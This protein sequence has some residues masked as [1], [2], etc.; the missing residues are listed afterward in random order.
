MGIGGFLGD[1]G[2]GIA[3]GL[4]GAVQGANALDR[5]INPFHTEQTLTPEG[6]KTAQEMGSSS[7]GL[8]A[9]GLEDTMSGMRWLYSN[10]VSQPLATAALVGKL[11]R[12]NNND[13]FGFDKDF[14]S[15]KSWT[16]SWHAANHISPGQAL[17]LNPDEAKQAI[18]SPLLYYKP[19]EAYLPPGFKN[20]P[21]DQQQELLHE[22]GMPAV[23]NAFIEKKRGD[24]SWFKYGTG[25]LDFASVT[26]ADPTAN[27]LGVVGKVRQLAIVKQMP[28]G[29][30]SGA[31]ID[32]LINQS[33]M[34]TLMKGIWLNKDNPQLINNT[35]LA[36]HSG[37][38]PRFGAIVSKLQDQDELNLFVRT[39]M[40]DMRAMD[41]LTMRNAAAG[42]RLR[43]DTSRLSAL[44][45]MKTR[46]S[47]QPN[48]QA[49]IDSEMNRISTSISADTALVDRYTSIVGDADA[50]IPGAAN[51]IDQ[52][53]VSR[54]SM[55]RAMDRTAAQNEYLAGPARGGNRPVTLRPSLGPVQFGNKGFGLN[56][57]GS[58]GVPPTPI[59]TG[60]I[61]SN[62]WGTGDYFSGPV[63]LVRSLKNFHPNG[64]MRVDV[65]DKDS[66]NELRGHLARIPGIKEDTRA[67]ILNSYL[68]T[69]TEAQRLDILDDVG[70]LGAAK[71]AQRHGLTPEDGEAFYREHTKRF[72]G[73]L[74]DMQRYSAALRSPDDVAAGMPLHV[75]EFT[76]DG[77]KVKLSPFT[78]TRLANG[79][80]FQDL[81]LFDKVLSRHA[82]KFQTLRLAMGNT[83]DAME[84]FADYSSFLWK[85]AALAR[86]GYIPRVLGDD[87][88]SQWARVG[89]AAMALRV[90]KGVKNAFHN[91]ALSQTRPA[92]EAREANARAGVGYAADEM[93]NLAPQIRK[94]EGRFATEDAARTRDV[95]LSQQRLAR[96]E[97]RLAN[98]GPDATE[99][100]RN[101]LQTFV[102]GKRNEVTRANTRA[103]SPTWP[104]KAQQLKDMKAQHDFL[105]RYHDLSARA[106]DDYAAQQLKARQ[107][108]Q[109]VEIDGQM[110]PAAFGGREGEYYHALTSA[111]DSVGNLFARN[112]QLVQ[113]N[114]ERSFDHGAKPIS[115][116]QDEVAHANAWTHAINNVIMQ[117]PLQ[118]MMV[119]GRINS[120]AEA[121][122]WMKTTPGG[123]AYR[124]RLPKYLNDEDIA[125]SQRYEIDSYMHLPEI[126]MK[127][128]E[129]GGVTPDFLKKATP[130]I[131][132][133]PDV[134]LGQVGQAQMRH[135]NALDRVI[136][137]WYR[138]AAT[139]PANKMS[140]H[141]LFNQFYEGH[142]KKITNQRK[143]QQG[144]NPTFT[145]KDVE[146]I[147]HASRQLALRDMR[148]LVFDIAHRS[149][150]A[151]ASRYM[152]PFFSATG[153]A[154]QRW[155]RVIADKPQIAGYAG[156]WYNAPAYN[157]AMQD[158]DGNTV[159]A[160]GN[161]YIPI[162]PLKADGTPDYTK[163]P[164]VVKRQVPKS[165]R[166]I[167]T[168][169]PK[170]FAE[171]PL[172]AAFNVTQAGGKLSLS[173]NSLDMVTQGDPWFNPGLGPIV[174]IPVNEL[175]KDKPRAAEM[176]RALG[177]LPFG[178]QG[179]GA[180]GDNPVGRAVNMAVPAQFRNF[181]TAYDTS[182]TR[183]QQI[184][185]Q[186]MQR[187]IYE[188]ENN[189]KKML[190][191]Q[192]IADQTRNYWLF[193]ASSSFLQPVATTRKDPYQF[194]RDQYNALRNQNP[195]TA[196]DQFLQR[197]GESY[198]I[199]AQEISKSVGVQPT[200]KAVELSKK[201]AKEIARNPDLAAL[202]IGP[203]GNGPFSPEAYQYE[204]NNP[205]TPG[206]AEMMRTKM[207]ADDAMKEN[208]RRLG[209]AK[210]TAKM[211]TV[212]ASLYKAGFKSFADDGAQDFAD[213]KK[214][215]TSLYAE[216]LYPD[217]SPNPY[218]NAEW[219]KDF[220]TTDQRKYERLIPGLT[221]LAN[222][223]LAKMPMRSD[224]R[225]LQQYLGGRKALVG[226]LNDLKNAGED[227]T[228]AAQANEG[229]R[230]Q[231]ISFVDG[232]VEADTRFGDL[233]H[234]YLSRDMG[235]DAVEEA[236]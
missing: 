15:A 148:S 205:L 97:A 225:M 135:A 193:S 69:S 51:Q 105:S 201:Y 226:Q 197:Y 30:W 133:R 41:E 28:K 18:E 219:S 113:G 172:G 140:R 66:L 180:F 55:Q 159:G 38:G 107:G 57:G 224:L 19:P 74:D 21:E 153:E 211:N 227:H 76:T 32:Q 131:I 134:H 184:K 183:Y 111:D 166:Y 158:L 210:Y 236:Q 52:L 174:Q 47:A 167:V 61:K 60:Y 230:N 112:K 86:L 218:Y 136:E 72:Q 92:L 163:K 204:L 187:A 179:G 3:H 8:L 88:A 100:Q 5:Y 182:D 2:D 123:L 79:H 199:F 118:K 56:H 27:A 126:R 90:G 157:G 181:L 63:T 150:A 117:D 110:F 13:P 222:S 194:Y 59:D 217:G 37:M 73:M 161:T 173:Q 155:G 46:Y 83:R 209:W 233:Y 1:I 106:A 50:G 98:L 4:E 178:V 128:M 160:D 103:K 48:M 130:N 10:G 202:I 115:A 143:L 144:G 176:A 119:Q 75:D 191:A 101:A 96:A 147:A 170:W 223:D 42:L 7:R 94:L 102:Q 22:A 71:V 214:A 77:G 124:A 12:R 9:P 234:R 215:W 14:F 152:S 68:K 169:V 81:D 235:V 212:T 162:Y 208:Q 80:T 23:G 129:D 109:A 203:E 25:A 137:R 17:S 121:V 6:K 151:A 142:L 116:A 195:L 171:S 156:N 43:S 31:N 132:D 70:R 44:D 220:F 213:Q 200:M 175:V 20:L 141:P 62:L 87:L 149:D 45:L 67:A 221:A 58:M 186:I 146:Q 164:Q 49:L 36:Q 34:Q 82:D 228:L 54:W 122:Q 177:V 229:L 11:G 33:H 232:L 84:G 168:R 65:L 185:L 91:I 207:S 189:G 231:W 108:N 206:G 125:Q 104:G 16:N 138:F 127:A 24:N 165:E 120:T 40:G 35:A 85:A 53:H 114:L 139:Q 95:S 29:G 192:Q 154:F 216:P 99:A 39:G 78:V 64:Y 145:V 26:F 89:T 196:D 188:H 190:S 93:G 198:F